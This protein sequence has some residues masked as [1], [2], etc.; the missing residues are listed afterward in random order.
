MQSVLIKKIEYFFVCNSYYFFTIT[1]IL[2]ST[3]DNATPVMTV[4][5]TTTV[6]DAVNAA[7]AAIVAVLN[8]L[9]A[10][11][12]PT[13]SI[14]TDAITKPVVC[15]DGDNNDSPVHGPMEL[16][17]ILLLTPEKAEDII[18]DSKKCECCVRHRQK[19]PGCFKPYNPTDY[20]TPDPELDMH[21]CESE[22]ESE[23]KCKC[24]CRFNARWI[25]KC[26]GVI[27]DNDPKLF[28]DMIRSHMSDH[29]REE[30]LKHLLKLAK[31]N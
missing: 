17:D 15:E 6:T 23:S 25:C 1:Q 12:V 18:K 10:I 26:Y 8:S 14:E 22:S 16:Y 30:L 13:A 11:F 24:A 19:K 29:K 5:D 4:T 31:E 3:P 9:R 7:T 2:S 20:E 27:N 21:E 28:E